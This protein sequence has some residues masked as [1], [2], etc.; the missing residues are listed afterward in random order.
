MLK[1]IGAILISA[2]TLTGFII[3]SLREYSKSLIAQNFEKV[4]NKLSLE[5]QKY[6]KLQNEQFETLKLIY[7]NLTRTEELF[8]EFYH[9]VKDDI[10]FTKEHKESIAIPFTNLIFQ[11]QRHFKEN[12]IF[13]PKILVPKIE[14][15][16]NA[17]FFCLTKSSK[18]LIIKSEEHFDENGNYLGIV[19][20]KFD[21]ISTDKLNKFNEVLRLIEKTK[22]EELPE[23]ILEVENEFRKIFGSK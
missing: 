20:K 16:I 8:N 6:T 4:K 3:W 23:L 14:K 12:K 7:S 19:S 10:E 15:V 22:N 5:N 1:E 2:T 13:I 17:L 18:A 9:I 11:M 21:E